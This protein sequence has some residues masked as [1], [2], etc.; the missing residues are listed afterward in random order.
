MNNQILIIERGGDYDELCRMVN[1]TIEIY[2]D[3]FSITSIEYFCMKDEESGNPT[4]FLL[5]T[6]NKIKE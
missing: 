4:A 1:K 5:F 2:H 3:E 6:R